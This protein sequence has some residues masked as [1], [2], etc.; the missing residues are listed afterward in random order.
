G[1]TAPSPALRVNDSP[2]LRPGSHLRYFDEQVRSGRLV[3]REAEKAA[4]DVVEQFNYERAQIFCVKEIK[5]HL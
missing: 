1:M 2:I 4:I 3:R 5:N